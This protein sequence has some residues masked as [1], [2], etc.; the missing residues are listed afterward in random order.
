MHLF[1][2]ALLGACIGAAIALLH[3]WSRGTGMKEAKKL[4]DVY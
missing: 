4:W 3:V 1:Q 2:Y